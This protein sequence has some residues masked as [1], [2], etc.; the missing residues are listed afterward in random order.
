MVMLSTS[1]FLQ[2]VLATYYDTGSLAANNSGLEET[3]AAVESNDDFACIM[4]YDTNLEQVAYVENPNLSFNVS[5]PDWMSPATWMNRTEITQYVSSSCV[6]GPVQSGGQYLLSFSRTVSQSSGSEDD[7]YGLLTVVIWAKSAA[8]ILE[9]SGSDMALVEVIG[10]EVR[11]I[12]P[13]QSCIDCFNQSVGALGQYAIPALVNDTAVSKM[14]VGGSQVA[15]GIAPVWFNTRHWALIVSQSH[16]AVYQPLYRLR[17]TQL[18]SVFSIGAGLCI[19]TWLLA[20]WAVKP[21]RKLQ[22]A[23]EQSTALMYPHDKTRPKWLLWLRR[24]GG[25]GGAGSSAKS[26]KS[27]SDDGGPNGGDGGGGA[28][29]GPATGYRTGAGTGVGTETVTETGWKRILGWL[30]FRSK[31]HLEMKSEEKQDAERTKGQFRIPDKVELNRRLQDEMTELTTTFN[32]MTEELRKQ[33][34]ILEERVEERTK[35]IESARVMAESANEAKSLFLANISHELRTPLNGILGMADVSMD[36]DDPK[37]VKESLKVIFKSGELLLKLLTDLLSFSKNQISDMDLEEKEFKVSEIVVQL[38]AIFQEQCRSTAVTLTIEAL[39]DIV[40]HQVFF[41][42]VNRILQV[43]INLVSNSLKF[44]PRGGHVTVKIVAQSELTPCDDASDNKEPLDSNQEHQKVRTRRSLSSATESSDGHAHDRNPGRNRADSMFGTNSAT[45]S[46]SASSVRSYRMPGSAPVYSSPS[47]DSWES[48]ASTAAAP[49]YLWVGFTVEDTGPG[50]AP[51]MQQ[52]IFEA[53]VQGDQGPLVRRRGVGLGLSICRQL[54]DRMHGSVSLKSELNKGSAFTFS[55]PLRVVRTGANVGSDNIHSES[56]PEYE[57]YTID[58][59]ESQASLAFEDIQGRVARGSSA[60]ST[61]TSE[62]PAM[63][64]GHELTAL[65]Q[66]SNDTATATAPA[67]PASAPPVP[68]AA[69][70]NTNTAAS[71]GTAAPNAVTSTINAN[72]TAIA[73][74]SGP[75]SAGHSAPSSA[76]PS[77][78]P[79]ISRKGS[80]RSH[81]EKISASIRILIAEDNRVNQ[82]VMVRML[83]L[84]GLENVDVVCDGCEAV[85]AVRKACSGSDEKPYDMIL[86]DIQMPKMDGREASRV[87][88][89]EFGFD[90]PIVAVSAYADSANINDCI[91]VGMDHFLAKPIR[92]PDLHHLLMSL[93]LA[94]KAEKERAGSRSSADKTDSAAKE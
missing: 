10:G 14:N 18:I 22:A 76:A 79:A 9:R 48:R 49:H 3:Q 27:D 47:K 34:A 2:D 93:F 74:T 17:N 13:P 51:H 61:P 72:T 29:P 50:I 38:K 37:S 63:S 92:R 4:L 8:E 32:N 12:Y 89:S 86:M 52:R 24:G 56:W 71:P 42:D 30:G 1:S 81:E 78:R 21:L 62:L 82:E 41:G 67:V 45:L 26:I 85:E 87:I 46:N 83:K 60:K 66:K 40:D 19:A 53:F 25:G 39:E 55:A 64:F 35:E 88:R 7:F 77:I 57:S 91:A 70:A 58:T 94:D 5:V 68:A 33:Y 20:G 59:I 80:H 36:D 75:S 31:T 69:S 65:S 84:E 11:Y 90:R 28:P 73:T 54:A 15:I 44:T 43:M 16:N 6:L 23:T